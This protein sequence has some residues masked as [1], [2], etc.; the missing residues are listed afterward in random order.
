M[1]GK[2]YYRTPVNQ[3][4]VQLIKMC[5]T[6]AEAKDKRCGLH[7]GERENT[8]I[9]VVMPLNDNRAQINK[10]LNVFTSLLDAMA[11]HPYVNSVT[12]LIVS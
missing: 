7:D 12:H 2:P 4:K 8:W 11:L 1:L 6:L 3:I 9:H 5:N 10:I